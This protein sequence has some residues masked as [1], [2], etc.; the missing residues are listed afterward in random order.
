MVGRVLRLAGARPDERGT[1]VI[2]TWIGFV[3][4]LG[5]LLFTV[6]A[7]LNLYATSVLTSVAW[8][9]AR[10]VAGAD[11]DSGAQASAEARAR[12][13]L[14]RFGEGVSF[15]WSASS[16]EDIVLRVRGGVP[17]VLLENFGGRM[18]F[19]EIDRTVRLRVERFRA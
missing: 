14:G 7:L 3:V 10:E 12:E 1:G 11:G 17:S 13:L 18:P 4:F 9:A 8:D 5:M 16:D 6:Q 2:S 19:G 15:D